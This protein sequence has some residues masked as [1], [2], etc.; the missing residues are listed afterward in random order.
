MCYLAQYKFF[1]GEK[2]TQGKFPFLEE[3]YVLIKL[4]DFLRNVVLIGFLLR[5]FKFP[6]SN[7]RTIGLLSM[8]SRKTTYNSVILQPPIL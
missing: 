5:F 7:R 4:Q 3:N 2:F 6:F 8:I 1:T